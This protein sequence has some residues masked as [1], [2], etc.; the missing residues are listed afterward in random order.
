M[1]G[2]EPP[3]VVVGG[4]SGT[5]KSTLGAALAARLGVPFVDGDD[6]HSDAA[7]AKMHAGHPLTDADRAPWL[8]RVAAVL[9]GPAGA[10]VACSALKRAYRDRL[11][12]AA[13]DVVTLML[14]APRA[15][16]EARLRARRGHFMPAS[17]LDSQL[18]TLD[19]PQPDEPRTAVVRDDAPPEAVLANAVA[20]VLAMTPPPP[21][22]PGGR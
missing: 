14:E 16:L 3:R 7:K 10:V 2:V 13:P 15:V 22:A 4:V 19:P 11:R 20:T 12:A 6:L 21:I 5:G 1:T 18:A 17:L 8:D 9:A